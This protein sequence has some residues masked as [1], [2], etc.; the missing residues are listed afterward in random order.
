MPRPPVVCAD[1][2]ATAP[3]AS[4]WGE[5]VRG[6]TQAEIGRTAIIDGTPSNGARDAAPCRI[7]IREM[8]ADSWSLEVNAHGPRSSFVAIAQ[9]WDRFW[10]AEVDGLLTPL[11]RREVSLSGLWIEPGEHN[12]KLIYH[13]PTVT[14]AEIVGLLGTTA[15]LGILLFCARARRSDHLPGDLRPQTRD[16][17]LSEPR[18]RGRPAQG[19]VPTRVTAHVRHETHAVAINPPDSV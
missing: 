11:E 8:S 18:S 19:A 9:T 4:G 3:G 13:D 6:L 10:R 16:E 15:S 1:R 2:V 14:A 12:V 5:V 17:A 7:T